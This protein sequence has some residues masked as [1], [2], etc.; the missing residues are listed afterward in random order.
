MSL[1]LALLLLTPGPAPAADVPAAM[2]VHIEDPADP[3]SSMT[4]TVVRGTEIHLLPSGT[5][6]VRIP[7]A[8]EVAAGVP[9][10]ARFADPAAPEPPPAVPG[11]PTALPPE[12]A[13]PPVEVAVPP[14]EVALAAVSPAADVPDPLAGPPVAAIVGSPME[15][16]AAVP[17]PDATPG[18]GAPAGVRAPDGEP[19]LPAFDLPEERPPLPS[20]GPMRFDG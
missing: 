10:V 15:R 11:L 1:L 4:L 20:P 13:V 17:E 8:W 19:D 12:A 14:V 18:G 5:V 9:A 7:G 3:A 6:V 2:T 16:H